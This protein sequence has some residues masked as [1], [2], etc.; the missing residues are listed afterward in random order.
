MKIMFNGVKEERTTGCGVCGSKRKS[1]SVFIR[2]KR[3]IL[4]SG[5]GKNFYQGIEY[6]INDSDAEFLLSLEY[7]S[8]GKNHKMFCEV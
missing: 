3:F 8:D 4:P 1:G 6:D 5:M 2:S 7:V